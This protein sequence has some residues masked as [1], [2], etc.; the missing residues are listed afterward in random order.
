MPPASFAGYDAFKGDPYDFQALSLRWAKPAFFKTEAPH[1]KQ[2]II[3]SYDSA[4]IREELLMRRGNIGGI[5]GEFSQN[6]MV[7]LMALQIL[8]I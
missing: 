4:G 5:W 6:N 7:S 8:Q 3:M 1:L 2:Y